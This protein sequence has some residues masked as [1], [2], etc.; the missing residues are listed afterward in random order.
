MA[1]GTSASMDSKV[2]GTSEYKNISLEKTLQSLETSADG[3][4]E[5]EV[6][7]QLGIFGYNVIA[8]KRKNLFLRFFLRYCQQQSFR[9][10]T[11]TRDRLGL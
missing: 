1:E 11:S 3:L 5:S 6:G 10:D 4:T 2:R 8:V 9:L 7:S